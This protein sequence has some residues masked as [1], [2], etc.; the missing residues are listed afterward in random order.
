[1][2][3]PS[4]GSVTGRGFRPHLYAYKC[5]PVTIWRNVFK[6]S[7]TRDVQRINYQSACFARRLIL[8]LPSPLHPCPLPVDDESEAGDEETELLICAI[9]RTASQ[10]RVAVTSAVYYRW[11][12]VLVMTC[13][14]LVITLCLMALMDAQC[15]EMLYDYGI[16]V[17]ID[18]TA[19][20]YMCLMSM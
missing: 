18:V 2:F 7:V 11:R 20:I 12:R 10:H 8:A 17:N 13:V 16:M 14:L 15:R 3:S 9:G 5:L 6:V 1:M 19:V 4:Y